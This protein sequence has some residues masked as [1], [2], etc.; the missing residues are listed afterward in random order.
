MRSLALVAV[1]LYAIPAAAR[2][3]EP[4]P[5]EVR[6]D[7][8]IGV[9]RLANSAS[10]DAQYTFTPSAI[11]RT[12]DVVPILR[13]FVRHPSAI[14]VRARRLGY[15]RESVT[16]GD[17]GGT[18]QLGPVYASG[19]VGFEHD[20]VD[21]DPGEH[22]YW[23]L[24]VT[25]EGGF[26]PINLLSLGGYYSS[27]FVVGNSLDDVLVVQAE[28]SGQD[29]KIGGHVAFATPNDRVYLNFWAWGRI[30]DWSFEGFHVG[31]VTI[32]GLG[33]AIRVAFQLTS[34][35]TIVVRGD[36]HRD[37]WVDK[38]MGDD[39]ENYVGPDLDRKVLGGSGGVEVFYWHRGR[40]GFRF[41][42]GGGYEG[43]PPT[44]DNRETGILQLNL[45]LI[46]RF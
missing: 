6:I 14:W 44:F 1:G 41:G 43:A 29:Q 21:Y 40:Y 35:F 28:R 2:E 32:R 3:A 13:R 34:A 39:D 9:E 5:H 17:V 8:D 19:E 31:D 16:G 27:R 45:G 11:N 24:P 33:A 26:R 15:T 12:D 46:T 7:L 42:L 22:A 38:R 30:T 36:L 18:L 25:L 20:L 37:H 10:F 4:Q 23:A